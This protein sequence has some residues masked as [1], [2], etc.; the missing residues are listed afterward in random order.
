[1]E[2]PSIRGWLFAS[3]GRGFGHRGARRSS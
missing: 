1:V 3:R 2:L